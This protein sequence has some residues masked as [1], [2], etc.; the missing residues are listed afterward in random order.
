M[1]HLIKGV[2]KR[3]VLGFTGI[4]FLIGPWN[5]QALHRARTGSGLR[6][7]SAT[8]TALLWLMATQPFILGEDSCPLGTDREA[9][10]WIHSQLPR[11][12]QGQKGTNYTHALSGL[13]GKVRFL[14][15]TK[16]VYHGDPGAA[17]FYQGKCQNCQ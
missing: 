2:F 3:C 11:C 10:L 1:K 17:S 5:K 7:G 9:A 13:E 8:H 15:I 12:S 4:T 16:L 6:R 14:E